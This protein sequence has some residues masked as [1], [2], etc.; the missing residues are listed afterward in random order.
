MPISYFFQARV[1]GKMFFQDRCTYRFAALCCRG[2]R[3]KATSRR[4]SLHA[5][6]N[7][8]H[9]CHDLIFFCAWD[10]VVVCENSDWP[11]NYNGQ[12]ATS[13]VC[14]LTMEHAGRSRDGM[15]RAA[16]RFAAVLPSLRIVHSP[17]PKRRAQ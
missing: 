3:H 14:R 6:E 15:V 5:V 12:G 17:F 11:E 13:S 1:E 4:D 2:N 8:V 16:E 10:V 7:L 9:Y